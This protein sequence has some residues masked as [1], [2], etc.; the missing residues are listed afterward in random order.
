MSVQ[1]LL[2]E[3]GELSFA[4]QTRVFASFNRRMAD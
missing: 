4:A 1:A 3:R 2:F